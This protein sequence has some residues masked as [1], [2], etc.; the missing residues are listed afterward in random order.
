M[1]S[2]NNKKYIDVNIFF[3]IINEEKYDKDYN[4]IFCLKFK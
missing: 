3:Y 1:Q 4:N 2:I